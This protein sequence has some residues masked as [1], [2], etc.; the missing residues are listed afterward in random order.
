MQAKFIAFLKI[1][2]PLQQPPPT[3]T[4]RPRWPCF[5]GPLPVA[6]SA[7]LTAITNDN[8]R[9]AVDAWMRNPTTATATYGHITWWDTQGVTD[10]SKLFYWKESFNENI[11][12]W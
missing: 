11:G 6:S 7:G 12:H 9:A 1:L 3:P 10:M 5:P 8:I 2:R 4:D